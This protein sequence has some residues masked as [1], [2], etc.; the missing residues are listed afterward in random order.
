MRRWKTKMRQPQAFNP[1]WLPRRTA[2]E[3]PRFPVELHLS[4]CKNPHFRQLR[5]TKWLLIV[6]YGLVLGKADGTEPALIGYN[7]ALEM[8]VYPPFFLGVFA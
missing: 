8:L 7:F 4:G 1:S 5:G 6:V 3:I 2:C